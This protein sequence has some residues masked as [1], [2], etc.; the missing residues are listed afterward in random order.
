M[1]YAVMACF[2]LLVAGC[3]TLQISADYDE[4]ADFA[5]L[6]SYAWLPAPKIK[7]GDPEIQYNSLLDQ[8]VRAAVETQLAEKGLARRDADADVLV[9]YHVVVDQ[10]VSV[11]Y[12]NE[13]YGY[14]PG[15]G[16]SYRRRLL[17]YGYPGRDVLVS[18]YQQGTLI[19]DMVR[20][21][22]QQLIWRGTASDEVYPDMS[23]DA[24]E[25]RVREA[26]EKIFAHY[27]PPRAVKL[28]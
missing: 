12:L 4:T 15:W 28:E 21:T 2:A 13:V 14:G 18:E 20:A 22:D 6:R 7:S 23:M 9:T 5:A 24:R 16:P 11:T 26:V 27:P 25:K 1:K 10:K 19:I 3:S 8:R 17:H